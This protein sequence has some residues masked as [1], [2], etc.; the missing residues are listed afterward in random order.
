MEKLYIIDIVEVAS[1]HIFVDV[2]HKST[3]LR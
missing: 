1:I 3:F 2:D